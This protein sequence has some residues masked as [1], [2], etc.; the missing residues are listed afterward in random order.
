MSEL[1]TTKAE[2][3]EYFGYL[4]EL[5]ESG[6]TNMFGAGKYVEE[7][8]DVNPKKAKAILLKWMSTFDGTSTV[9]ERVNTILD[10]QDAKK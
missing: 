3:K 4:D 6:I 5:R 1:Q 8:F 9:E 7:A 2:L 10:S